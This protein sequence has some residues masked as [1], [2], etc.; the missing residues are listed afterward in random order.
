MHKNKALGISPIDHLFNRLDGMYVGKWRSSFK[1]ADAIENWRN[2]WSKELLERGILPN[3]KA[4]QNDFSIINRGLKNCS[5][6][7]AWPPSL[8][9]FIKA[10]EVPSRDEPLH[11][12][13]PSL[14]GLPPPKRVM[15]D[16]VK[17]V[18]SA[19]KN[20]SLLKKVDA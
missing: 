18:F 16:D 13:E 14:V 7:Y 1:S 6:M 5:S 11:R 8:A 15:P 3:S 19:I 17:A 9:E 10:C 2:E 20:R 4:K 12:I